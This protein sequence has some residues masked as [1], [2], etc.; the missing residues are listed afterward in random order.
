MK[1]RESS[2]GGRAGAGE[3]ADGGGAVVAGAE[4]SATVVICLKIEFVEV[5]GLPASFRDRSWR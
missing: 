2:R 4:V 1:S 3:P 5:D